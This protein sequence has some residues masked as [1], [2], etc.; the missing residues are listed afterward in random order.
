MAL[1][2]CGGTKMEHQLD[3]L[4]SLMI[5]VKTYTVETLGV[6]DGTDIDEAD[7]VTVLVELG[8]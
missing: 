3:K 4:E 5:H 6:T 2:W 8:V 1:Y 7:D